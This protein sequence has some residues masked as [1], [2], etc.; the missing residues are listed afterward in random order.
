ML[1]TIR[2]IA[3]LGAVYICT[4]IFAALKAETPDINNVIRD[5]EKAIVNIR[6]KY[7]S[8]KILGF[9]FLINTEGLVLT[10]SHIIG[11]SNVVIDGPG[12]KTYEIK[13]IVFK[14]IN[15]DLALLQLSNGNNLPFVKLGNSQGLKRGNKVIAITNY[16]DNS[17]IAAN[18]TINKLVYVNEN[19]QNRI[20]LENTKEIPA[21]L[22]GSPIFNAQG[23]VIGILTSVQNNKKSLGVYAIAI[24]DLHNYKEK[25]KAYLKSDYNNS[26][27]LTKNRFYKSGHPQN[28]L[29]SNVKETIKASNDMPSDITTSNPNANLTGYWFDT[30]TGLN[31]YLEHLGQTITLKYSQSSISEDQQSKCSGNFKR[32]DNKYIGEIESTINCENLKIPQNAGK[33]QS[34]FL[35]E[36]AEIIS[37]DNNKIELKVNSISDYNCKLCTTP[38]NVKWRYRTWLKKAVN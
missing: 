2:I 31:L 9:G 16:A 21:S 25:I 22:E 13:K 19:S 15:K 5:N 10:N 33:G 12:N 23:E 4:S 20:I 18:K 36:P 30:E 32:T 29:I 14:D 11:S 24:N 26:K 37:W 34:C 6:E 3:I 35:R 8:N 7:G 28:N 1:K 17:Y 38:E 27:T